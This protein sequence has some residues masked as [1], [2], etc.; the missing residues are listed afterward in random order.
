MSVRSNGNPNN[1]YTGHHI[2]ITGGIGGSGGR[3]G[4]NG[5]GNGERP[6]VGFSGGIQSCTVHVSGSLFNQS[7]NSSALLPSDLCNIPLG[8][9]FL[10]RDLSEDDTEFYSVHFQPTQHKRSGVR[11]VYFAKIEGRNTG[12]TVALYEGKRAEEQFKRDLSQYMAIRHPNS[13]QIHG[14]MHSPHVHAAIF[15]GGVCQSSETYAD[16]R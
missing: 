7:T 8:D 1:D 9:I 6:R 13:M 11:K 16:L 12:M 5:G 15:H 2:S 4:R 14:I 10:Q 3:G